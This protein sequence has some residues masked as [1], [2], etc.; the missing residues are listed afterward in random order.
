MG[1][2]PTPTSSSSTCAQSGAR[3]HTMAEMTVE[4]TNTCA[5]VASEITARAGAGTK[6]SDN[7][8]DPHNDGHYFLQASNSNMITTKRYTGNW[9]Y[10]DVQTF[11]LTSTSSGGCSLNACSVSQ[12]FCFSLFE[13]G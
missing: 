3:Q 10:E 5:E 2:G 13:N 1:N 4:F 7:W 12:G 9:R 11:A 6:N 8:K